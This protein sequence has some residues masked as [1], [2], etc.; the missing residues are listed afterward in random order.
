MT[1]S[2]GQH[3]NPNDSVPEDIRRSLL[4]SRSAPTQLSTAISDLMQAQ[5]VGKEPGER[6]FDYDESRSA[7]LLAF[8]AGE[9]RE[10][11]GEE[12]KDH[13]LDCPRCRFIYT[14]VRKLVP[15]QSL[16]VPECDPPVCAEHEPAP[17]I[18]QE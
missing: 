11:D 7:L 10:Q 3:L 4:V 6:C 17:A 13:L 1:D 16:Q 5:W 14:S 18:L 9:T 15:A 8:L 12:V 2:S